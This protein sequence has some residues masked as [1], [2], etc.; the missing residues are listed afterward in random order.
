[1]SILCVYVCEWVGGGDRF[2]LLEVFESQ[3]DGIKQLTFSGY[4]LHFYNDLCMY[5]SWPNVAFFSS[6]TIAPK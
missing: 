2:C 3:V 4:A 5:C 1:M 6:N